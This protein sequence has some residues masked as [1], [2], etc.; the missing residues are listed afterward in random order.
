MQVGVE[1]NWTK[2]ACLDMA[3][4]FQMFLCLEE[5]FTR[6]NIWKGFGGDLEEPNVLLYGNLNR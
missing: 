1:K 2:P 6:W 3:T 5:K 4:F